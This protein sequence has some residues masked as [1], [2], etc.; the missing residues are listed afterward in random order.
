MNSVSVL[1]F[2]VASKT[3]ECKCNFKCEC[4]FRLINFKDIKGVCNPTGLYGES[5]QVWVLSISHE[6]KHEK[7]SEYSGK[8]GP[9]FVSKTFQKKDSVTFRS[10]T[11]QASGFP[12]RRLA[13]MR[14]SKLGDFQDAG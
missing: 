3:S 1:F 14:L 12:K 6:T 11:L 4:N 5:W 10:A 13:N 9:S 2:L 8:F 7:S